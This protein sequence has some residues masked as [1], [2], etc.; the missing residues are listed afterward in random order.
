LLPVEQLSVMLKPFA[1]WWQLNLTELTTAACSAAALSEL[2]EL[3]LL[4]ALDDVAA[5]P[6]P[7]PL[8]ALPLPPDGIVFTT[9]PVFGSMM[10]AG[11]RLEPV[12]WNALISVPADESAEL[13]PI[14]PRFQLS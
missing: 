8:L 9:S 7:A 14:R 4:D 5:L 2:A 11:A 6:L 12:N 13:L 3:P 1:D 10:I